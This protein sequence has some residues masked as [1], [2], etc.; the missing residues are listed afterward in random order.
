MSKPDMPV[1]HFL[2]AATFRFV[3]ACLELIGKLLGANYR[4]HRNG[5]ASGPDEGVFWNR[6]CLLGDDTDRRGKKDLHSIPTTTG[7][8][9]TLFLNS[10]Q[11]YR[12]LR[13]AHYD[14]LGAVTVGD[15]LEDA[16]K[17]EMRSIDVDSG[18]ELP[19]RN[20]AVLLMKTVTAKV[21]DQLRKEYATRWDER[22]F[23]DL[24]R[25]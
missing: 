5:Y 22:V 15:A 11:E 3:A 2:K 24:H 12:I 16:I 8:D 9:L 23:A 25:R 20:Q 1:F 4:H 17:G 21:G 6:L 13:R 10:Q 18:G 19:E 7:S 14:V